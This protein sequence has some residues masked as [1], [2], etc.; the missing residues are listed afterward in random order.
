MFK[1]I[2]MERGHQ[3]LVLS[4]RSNV[5]VTRFMT[6]DLTEVSLESQLLWFDRI[7]RDKTQKY[8]IIENNGV[9][10]GVV[11][12]QDISVEHRRASWGFY[13]GEADRRALAAF[14]LPCFYNYLF[15]DD[16]N[17]WHLHKL[18]GEVMSGNDRVLKLHQFHG[19]RLVGT[20][21]EH[22]S[23][24]ASFHDMNIIELTRQDWQLNGKKFHKYRGEWGLAADSSVD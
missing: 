10:I 7:N 21:R 4:W 14:V 16:S 8:W 3:H 22:V 12:L 9:A 23:K 20:L 24:Y 6:S 19:H 13:I 5:D 1:F 18:Y 2:T 17:P 15:L 11:N